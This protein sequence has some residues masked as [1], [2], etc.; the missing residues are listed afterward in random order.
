MQPTV[1]LLC[2]IQG[3]TDCYNTEGP[4]GVIKIKILGFVVVLCNCATFLSL[5][6][7]L[8]KHMLR[9]SLQNTTVFLFN[10]KVN[11]FDTLK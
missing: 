2:T 11:R 3:A 8:L 6:G 1:H 5:Y 9:N 4:G 7:K 10:Q